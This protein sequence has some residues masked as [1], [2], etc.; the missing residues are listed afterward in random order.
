MDKAKK[1]TVI[2][3]AA[4][5]MTANYKSSQ[6]PMYGDA[7]RMPNRNAVI[8]IIRDCQKLIFP[9][10]YGDRD[11]LKLPPEQYSALLME[12]IHEKLTRQITL[13]MPECDE[14]CEVAY[15]IS[16]AFIERIPAIQELL[17]KDLSANFEGDPAAYSKEEVLLSYPGMFAIFIYRI[18][19]ELY[20]N[21]V[22]MIPRMMSE[23]AHSQT[24]IDINPGAKIGEY[25]FI[26][27]GTGV[28]VGETT[29]IGDNVK[30]YQG[31]TLGAL[32]PAGMATN[33]NVRRHPKVGNNVVIY[34]NSTL[35]GGATE[36]GDNVVVGGNAFLTS[37]VAPN[38]VVS[39]K[40]PEMT[41]RGKHHRGMILTEGARVR[42]RMMRRI[43]IQTAFLCSFRSMTD[44]LFSVRQPRM[45]MKITLIPSGF[46][47]KYVLPTIAFF[48]DMK[49]VFHPAFSADR[50]R[51]PHL[52][53]P[54]LSVQFLRFVLPASA[55]HIL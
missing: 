12:H 29:I 22:A 43:K 26:D 10:Y 42:L 25:F 20:E 35:L 52:S 16:T 48:R 54:K 4:D 40:N 53:G 33:P 51:N 38:T 8:E 1:N 11:L 37:S 24:G 41:F 6:I 55:Q 45:R 34:A 44:R 14:N 9:V 23:Y 7:L 47:T 28:V 36:I 13:T 19:H 5:R 27:H 17:L 2:H 15:A 39:V 18:A 30:L 46:R 50:I 49:S 31:A 21:K 3:A 32:S